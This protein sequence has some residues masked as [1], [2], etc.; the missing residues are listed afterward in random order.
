VR[1]IECVPNISEGR[2]LDVI[3][4]IAAIVS[5]TPGV[6]LLDRSTDRSHHR[7]VLTIVGQAAP[8]RTAVLA[9]IE[10]AVRLID[11][12]THH[13]VHPRVGAV[14]VVP[15][16]PLGEVTMA[17]CAA[18][19]REVAAHAAKACALPVYLYEEAAL[20]PGR[21]RLEALRRGQFEGLAVKMQDP[22]WRPDFGPAQPHATAGATVIGARDLL[23][24]YNINLAT[25]RLEVARQVA[26][27]IRESNGGLPYVK[28][29][30]VP[31]AERGI[32]QVSMNLTNFAVTSMSRVFERVRR[33]AALRGAHVLE[34]EIVGLVPA[35]ALAN[36]S[37][38]SLMLPPSA[39][40]KVLEDRLAAAG[41]TPS[42]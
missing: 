13:G 34:S 28:A 20:V 30:G 36:Q 17:E 31:L 42:A 38:E 29:M 27:V 8:L 4:S 5:S 26:A 21:Q 23:L 14:D 18:L 11:V 37:L 12:R 16:V 15:F 7:T 22:N 39:A 6:S 33:E 10:A 9:M 3:D 24:A 40:S 2:R 32:V 35:A 25:D 1:I 19:A 41:L